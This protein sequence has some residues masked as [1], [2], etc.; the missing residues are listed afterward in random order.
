MVV[1]WPFQIRTFSAM[2]K[3]FESRKM[4]TTRKQFLSKPKLAPLSLFTRNYFTVG[5]RIDQS[6]IAT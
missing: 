4:Q 6:E 3:L 2:K 5:V 1:R